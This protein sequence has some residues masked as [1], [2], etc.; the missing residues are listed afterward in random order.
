MK[1][2]FWSSVRVDHGEHVPC[3]QGWCW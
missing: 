3:D 1:S 2:G